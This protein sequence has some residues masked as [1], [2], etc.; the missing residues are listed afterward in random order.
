MNKHLYCDTNGSPV[1][2]ASFS[3]ED[4]IPPDPAGFVSVE[5]PVTS[6]DVLLLREYCLQDG[7]L[8]QRGPRPSPYYEWDPTAL[9][10]AVRPGALDEAKASTRKNVDRLRDQKH[11]LPITVDG[12]V[13][14]ADSQSVES[15]RGLTA[16]VD[17]GDGLTTGWV[18]WRTFDNTMVWTDW[19]AAQVLEGLHTVSRA[20]E[21]R[22]QALLIAAWA[23]K[24]VIETLETLEE[25]TA[26]DV[27]A[28]WPE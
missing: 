18:G 28:G 24:A 3:D 7:A 5:V 20:I 23:H 22:K 6:D 25:V 21:D 15:I 16:R 26:Y 1:Y 14:D 12:V 4:S 9:S 13:F 11:G 2:T 17:R 8:F 27:T 19:P 10:W